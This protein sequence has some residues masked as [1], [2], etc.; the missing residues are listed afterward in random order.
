M[1]P[2]IRP[3]SRSP[4]SPKR[5]ETTR[6]CW[7]ATCS[8]PRSSMWWA[9]DWPGSP[10]WC[11]PAPAR[12]GSSSSVSRSDLAGC[13]GGSAYADWLRAPGRTPSR[14]TD[15]HLTSERGHA[16]QLATPR[17][18]VHHLDARGLAALVSRLDTELATE[19]LAARGPRVAAEVISVSHPDVGERVLRAMPHRDAAETVAAMPADR[20]TRWQDR[21]AGSP[22]LLD[23]PFLRSQVWPRR[24]HAPAGDRGAERPKR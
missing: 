21:L 24:R 19:I 9:S 22:T 12:T 1:A 14:G 3:H 23:R 11:S 13:C 15:L 17:S 5:W 6:S 18:A 4:R 7:G 2:M 8:T 20:A 16:V 10:K